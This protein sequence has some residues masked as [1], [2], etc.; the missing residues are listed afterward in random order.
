MQTKLETWGSDLGVRIPK[1]L[2]DSAQIKEGETLEIAVR[3]GS[4]VIT[5]A[6]GPHRKSLGELFA[7]YSEEYTCAEIDWGRPEGKEIW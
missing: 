2:L 1:E 5:K 7:G 3:E 4:L 6:A